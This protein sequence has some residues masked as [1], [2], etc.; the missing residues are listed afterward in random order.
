[1]SQQRDLNIYADH[2][3]YT[4]IEKLGDN[5]QKIRQSAEDAVIGMCLHPAFGTRVCITNLTSP[6][7]KD[8]SGQGNVKKSMNSN[9]QIIGKYNTLHRILA[10]QDL[11]IEPPMYEQSLKF[12]ITGV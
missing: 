7:R 2:I 5:L 6:P 9:K 12:S 8:P 1:M 3:L 11:V 4:L 10:D